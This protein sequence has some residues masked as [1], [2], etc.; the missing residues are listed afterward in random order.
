MSRH[1]DAI[2]CSASIER[3]RFLCPRHWRM[4]PLEVQRT[5]ND[6]YRTYRKDFAFLSDVV[7]LDACIRAIERI[8]QTEG[9]AFVEG[10]YHRLL[11][12]ARD[13]SAESQAP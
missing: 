10:S 11:R 12:V 9:Q 1:C 2:G 3:G 5:I 7:Y 13:R 6:R 4:V 8:A